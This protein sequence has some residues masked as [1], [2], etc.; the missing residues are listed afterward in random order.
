[1]QALT[2]D[3]LLVIDAID[4]KG[5]F[6]GAADILYRVPSAITYTVQKLEQDLG[7][8]LFTKEGRRS[9]L[10]PAGRLLLE[11]GRDLLQQA[12]SLTNDVREMHSGWESSL[13]I[14]IDSALGVNHIF[15]ALNYLFSLQP[16]IEINIYEEILAGGIEALLEKRTDIVLGIKPL[17]INDDI[18]TQF[19][20][21]ITWAFVVPKDHP[22]SLLAEPLQQQHIA[23]YRSVIVRDSVKNSAALNYRLFSKKPALRVSS[24][25]EKILA[26]KAGLGVGFLPLAQIQN[27]LASGEL[28]ALS[29]VGI[30]NASAIYC[31][32]W[33]HVRGKAK[34]AFLAYLLDKE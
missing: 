25:K 26:Q 33:R 17:V 29:V 6:A 11:R 27:E 7:V 19:Y 30:D 23:E 31:S 12:T 8:S 10:T 3:A 28:V 22:L 21:D 9:V 16:N 34:D 2:L 1:M 32:H 18:E 15:P 5:T 20:Q 4:K 13:H 14:S 24:I